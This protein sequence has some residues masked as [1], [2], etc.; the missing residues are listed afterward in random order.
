MIPHKFG[1]KCFNIAVSSHKINGSCF[2]IDILLTNSHLMNTLDNRE[3]CWHLFCGK[4]IFFTKCTVVGQGKNLCWSQF[5][6]TNWSFVSCDW[7]MYSRYWWLN[8]CW[9]T[10]WPCGRC[11]ELQVRSL[12]MN[13][14][15]I[16]E[17][18][19]NSFSLSLHAWEIRKAR[20]H[21][22][23]AALYAQKKTLP[24]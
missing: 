2:Q 14:H 12:L 20:P 17:G 15:P 5:K 8:C 6:I 11:T 21:E 1:R 9:E 4:S 23:H 18:T 10:Q 16:Q 7:L 3:P 19:I 22:C 24:F 13:L